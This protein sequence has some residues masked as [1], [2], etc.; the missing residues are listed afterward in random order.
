MSTSSN[1]TTPSNKTSNTTNPS[2][3]TSNTTPSNT[4]P[5]NTTPS[6]KTS[7]TT[8]PSNTTSNT[9]NPPTINPGLIK[10][11][12]EIDNYFIGTP[13][14]IAQNKVN[15]LSNQDLLDEKVEGFSNNLYY[16]NDDITTRDIY[17]RDINTALNQQNALYIA[18]T[19]TCATLLITALLIAR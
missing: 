1:N 9:T 7:N 3:T 16:D 11:Q 15:I 19:I 8:K 18:G 2:N 10:A 13:Q 12:L 5:S 6:N 4:T 14:S 17:E